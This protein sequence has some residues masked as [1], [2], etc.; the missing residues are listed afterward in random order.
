MSAE[1]SLS[2]AGIGHHYIL[3]PGAVALSLLIP[4]FPCLTKPFNSTPTPDGKRASLTFLAAST[5]F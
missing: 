2:W 3:R 4:S 5:I 1:V